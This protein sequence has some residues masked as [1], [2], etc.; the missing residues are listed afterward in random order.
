MLGVP[1]LGRSAGSRK[2]SSSRCSSTSS[3]CSSSSSGSNTKQRR[4]NRLSSKLSLLSSDL[5]HL[6]SSQ[7]VLA[8]ALSLPPC[9]IY[10][11]QDLLLL[12]QQLALLQ[13]V[14]SSSSS[15]KRFWDRSI[16]VLLLHKSDGL[17]LP[18]KFHPLAA[19]AVV[20]AA[21]GVYVHLLQ[22]PLVKPHLKSYTVPQLVDL[23]WHLAH[24]SLPPSS[25]S[26][27]ATVPAAS[28]AAAAAAVDDAAAA[29]AA[30]A[31]RANE[32]K[33]ELLLQLQNKQHALQ[34]HLFPQQQQHQQQQ[35]QQLIVVYRLV[36]AAA[37]LRIK[38]AEAPEVFAAV[39]DKGESN[40]AT[41]IAAATAAAAAAVAAAR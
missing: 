23:L 17:L 11:K 34:R 19:V 10:T 1:R 14:K 22:L 21:A 8:F 31:N 20:A 36:Y 6:T 29:T 27:S 25:R 5:R 38:A 40:H 4:L 18:V 15:F 7:Q 13:P 33:E 37:K 28:A 9:Y 3:S 30:T 12:L 26:P 41:I 39:S 24:L 16:P 2:G 35:Q 32:F